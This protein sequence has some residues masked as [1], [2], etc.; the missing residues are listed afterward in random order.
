MRSTI[1]FFA[2]VAWAGSL[3]FLV[4]A[5]AL[6]AAPPSIRW[7]EEVPGRPMGIEVAGL[8]AS[9]VEEL[10]KLPPEDPR[11][12]AILAVFVDTDSAA[13]S[14]GD[15]LPPMLGR[16]AVEG[17]SLRFTPRFAFRPGMTYRV[18]FRP[19]QAPPDA[20]SILQRLTTPP[21]PPTPPTRVVAI[22]PSSS[23]LPENQLRF[24]LHFSAPMSAG[25]AY[26]HIQLWTEDGRPVP[27]AF[28]EIGEELW[29]E[30]FERLTL[31]FDPGRVKHGLKPR[32][33]FGPVL[34]AGQRYVLRVDHR[35]QDAAGQ[36]LAADY[37]KR[38]TA[39]PAV[40][41]AVDVALWKIVPPPAGSRQPLVVQFDRPLDRA[42]LLRMILVEGPAGQQIE[43]QITLTDAERTWSFHPADAWQAGNYA[44][45]V[46]TALEDSAGNNLRR[47]FEVD[48]FQQVDARPGPE[49]V[50]IPWTIGSPA[51]AGR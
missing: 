34:V 38:F 48:V 50:R 8:A 16:Y 43:G 7:V 12:P 32:E 14:P 29:D 40:E 5:P 37:E 13:T 24:Y 21:P 18:E 33:E 39:G 3:V 36:P 45:V 23:V 15:R 51:G 4:V 30:R 47:P 20:P 6:S 42:L 44:L 26:R 17:E 22:Y 25:Q 35:W 2:K 1:G 46:D 19:P 27:R 41:T 11:W 28:L 31:L 49:W 9:Q 10:A